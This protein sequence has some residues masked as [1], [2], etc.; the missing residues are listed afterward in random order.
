MTCPTVR[1]P[2]ADATNFGSRVAASAPRTDGARLVPFHGADHGDGQGAGNG[3]GTVA[4]AKL[5]CARC[6]GGSTPRP[7][8]SRRRNPG[9]SATVAAV[10]AGSWQK[11]SALVI[12]KNSVPP[13]V[14][15]FRSTRS[16]TCH[17]TSHFFFAAPRREHRQQPGVRGHRNQA[18]GF[19]VCVAARA[20][21]PRFPSVAN[22]PSFSIEPIHCPPPHESRRLHFGHRCL[23][24]SGLAGI[25]P[26]STSTPSAPPTVPSCRTTPSSPCGQSDDQLAAGLD[27]VTDGEQNAAGFQFVLLE[28]LSRGHR[29]GILFAASFRFT[30]PDQRGRS[31]S[32]LGP[33]APLYWAWWRNS[34]ACK[35]CFT[36]VHPVGWSKLPQG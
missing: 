11:K 3:G 8:A 5:R 2:R 9:R 21:R 12:M 10:A 24:V 18:I 34:N 7:A 4:R 32:D 33:R 16:G 17:L 14:L 6:R 27:V 29:I 31:E 35:G 13:P 20:R 15:R 1:C 30:W 19:V 28:W 22:A 25:R 26:R 23:P 36:A